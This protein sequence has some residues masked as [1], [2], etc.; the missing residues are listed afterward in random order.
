M[1]L[2][3]RLYYTATKLHNA[4]GFSNNP[5]SRVEKLTL[6]NYNETKGTDLHE[7]FRLA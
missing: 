1:S 6:E 4:V 3:F 2:H 5:K 7:V